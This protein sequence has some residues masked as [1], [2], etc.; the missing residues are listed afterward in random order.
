M[1]S[2]ELV[3]KITKLLAMATRG[4]GN[5]AEV[6]LKKA[7]EL[8]EAHGLTQGDI[9][10]FTADI[11]DTKRKQRWVC[12]LSSMAATF[13]GVVCIDSYKMFIFAGD[14]LGVNVA[15]ELFFYLKKEILRKTLESK[16][17][18]RKGK[19]DF[20]IG[21]V[22]GLRERLERLGGWRDMKLKQNEIRKKHFAELKSKPSLGKRYVNGSFL[23]IGR[24]EAENI[25]LN[26][27]AG[28]SGASGYLEGER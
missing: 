2:Q 3:Q 26:R 10:L 6:A 27:Q 22:I 28:Y 14:E 12:Y 20:K 21:V 13:S 1:V 5:E 25:S 19:H 7:G 16:I 4:T 18:G 17:V 11:P 15:R 24:Q 9:E 8:M 23:E